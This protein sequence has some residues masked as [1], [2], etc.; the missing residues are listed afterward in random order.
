MVAAAIRTVFARPDAEH[1][2]EQ[3]EV[4]S[5]SGGPRSREPP[6]RSTQSQTCR[7]T[8]DTSNRTARTRQ[9]CG[10]ADIDALIDAAARPSSRS[11][12]RLQLPAPGTESQP[13]IRQGRLEALLNF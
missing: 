9:S 13:E 10:F 7:S 12:H 11:E 3:F 8:I 6:V 2:S 1:V 5:S 4:G